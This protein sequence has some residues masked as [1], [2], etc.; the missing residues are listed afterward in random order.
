M[1]Q[2][3]DESITRAAFASARALEPTDAEV[4]AVLTR[5]G[6]EPHAVPVAARAGACPRTIAARRR[7]VVARRL[8]P[9]TAALLVAAGGGYAVAA[10][11][12]AAIDDV[13]DTF[14]SWLGGDGGAAPGRPL[15]EGDVAP[16]YFRDPRYAKEPRVIAQAGPYKLFAARSPH[17]GGGVTFD[18]GNSGVGLGETSADAFRDRAVYVLGPAAMQ[19]MDRDGH[20]PLFGITARSVTRVELT[21]ESGPP[22]RADDIAGA[23]VLLAEPDRSPREVVAF[24]AGGR[25][26]G[27][28]LV[29]DS[30]HDGPRIDWTQYGPPATFVPARCQPGAAGPNPP[31]DCPNG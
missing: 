26:R 9:I 29:D 25:E 3:H 11:V 15:D 7:R 28:Q 20:V 31:A 4:A 1:T 13:A 12:R 21:Y 6:I 14:G 2:L 5:A 23:F 19:N 17:G 16:D 27:R 10:P 8:A 24:D 30:S 18:L 22:L